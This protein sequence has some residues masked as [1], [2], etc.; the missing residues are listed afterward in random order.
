MDA[1]VK[2]IIAHF[3]PI[4][5]IVALVLNSENK[6]EFT[7]FYIR[8]TIGLYIIGMVINL[9]PVVGWIL[10][11]VLFAFWLLSLIY[12]V[13]G[14]MKTIPFGEHFQMWFKAL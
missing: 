14:E 13:Q 1:R 4:G 9:I 11:I 2:A 10:S 8:Q 7:S 5:W 12:A 3:T 6:E